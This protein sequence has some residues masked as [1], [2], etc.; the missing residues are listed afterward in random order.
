MLSL[1]QIPI[2]RRQQDS[3]SNS[4]HG[5]MVWVEGE[6]AGLEQAAEGAESLGK[7]SSGVQEAGSDVPL[8][9][10]WF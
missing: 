7:L 4:Q 2:F 1:T 3:P 5:S 10:G 8:R 6:L 9:P